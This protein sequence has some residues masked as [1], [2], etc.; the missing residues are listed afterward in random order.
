MPVELSES[1]IGAA[2]LA[3]LGYAMRKRLTPAFIMRVMPCG[4]KSM[5]AYRTN[6]VAEPAPTLGRA[7]E[8]TF[9]QARSVAPDVLLEA[10]PERDLSAYKVARRPEPTP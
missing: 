8:T 2:K 5:L 9:E 3:T 4:H 10:T 7:G 6:A 1:A